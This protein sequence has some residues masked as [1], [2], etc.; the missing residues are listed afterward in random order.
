[1]VKKMKVDLLKASK[2]ADMKAKK[3][4]AAARIKLKKARR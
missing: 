1:M 4:F 3:A 2:Y